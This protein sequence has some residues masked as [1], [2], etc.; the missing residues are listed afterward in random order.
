ME[1]V[2]KAE[3]KEIAALV[4]EL[5]ERQKPKFV[6]ETSEG[7]CFGPLV[8]GFTTFSEDNQ[9]HPCPDTRTSCL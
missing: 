8:E 5:Q 3:P 6:P 7:V 2:I 1:V 9:R 4:L